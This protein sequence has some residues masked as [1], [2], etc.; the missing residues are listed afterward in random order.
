METATH[1]A[2]RGAS[3]D[4]DSINRR[5]WAQRD[6]V[7]VYERLQGLTDPGEKAA[8]EFVAGAARGRPILDIGVG[9][10]RTTQL[11]QPISQNYIAIDYTQE[12]VDAFRRLH[13]GVRCERMDARDL[14]AFGD[15]QFELVVF[16]F[17]GIDAVDLEGRMKV[18]REVHRV[19]R[20]GGR[21][22]FSAHNHEG[23]G[24]REHP[25]LHI[26][27]TWNPIKLGWRGLKSIR[28]LPR[29][30][31]N[32]R[33]LRALNESHDGW[34]IANAGAHDFGIVVMYTTLDETK[35]QLRQA[36]FEVEAV[37]DSTRGAPVGDGADTR[38]I[39]WF[40]YVAHKA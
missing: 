38:D 35:R 10:G 9:A 12:M 34:S 33:R 39:F 31:M 14:S 28:A 17:N 36:G 13:P 2:A 8:L 32:H 40:H 7:R 16:S 25:Q 30:L 5:T 19:L 21:F 26:P 23:P 3:R 18:L 11:L 15:G 6:T 22:L 4:L 24:R 1:P 27:F 37:F 20:P 29:S